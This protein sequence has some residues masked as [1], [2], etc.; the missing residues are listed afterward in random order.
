MDLEQ[1]AYRHVIESRIRELWR[2]RDWY[3]THT[4]WIVQS[5]LEDMH[6]LRQLVHLARRARKIARAAEAAHDRESRRM[7]EMWREEWWHA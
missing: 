2:W 7:A 6:E 5:Y 4:G 1:R 3:R